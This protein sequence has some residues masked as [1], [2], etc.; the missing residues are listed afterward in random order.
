MISDGKVIG[1]YAFADG[2]FV[3]S[4][5]SLDGKTLEEVVGLSYEKWRENWKNKYEN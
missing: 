5:Y 2:T 1:G 3:G 4:V